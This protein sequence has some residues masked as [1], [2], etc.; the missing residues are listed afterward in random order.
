[1]LDR[2]EL[3]RARGAGP[4]LSGRHRRGARAPRSSFLAAGLDGYADGR[5]EPAAFQCSLLSPYLHFGQISPV[6]IALAVRDGE[7]KP[8]MPT[9]PPTSRS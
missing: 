9:A 3:D 8:A 1:M 5:S 7:V 2:L 4:P 6:E